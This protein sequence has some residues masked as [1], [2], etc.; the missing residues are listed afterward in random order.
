[1]DAA[2]RELVGIARLLADIA[3]G[4]YDGKPALFD[5]LREGPQGA[6]PAADLEGDDEHRGPHQVELLLH[7]QGP[8][9]AQRLG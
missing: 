8:Q 3:D 4:R 5:S 2:T 9:V 1:M 6:D 7:G